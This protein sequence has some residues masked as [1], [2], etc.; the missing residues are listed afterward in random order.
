MNAPEMLR[1]FYAACTP[2][3]NAATVLRGIGRNKQNSPLSSII[4]E[5]RFAIFIGRYSPDIKI[6]KHLFLCELRGFCAK[7]LNLDFFHFLN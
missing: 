2:H 6:A 4:Q 7:I 5:Y 3:K 1:H